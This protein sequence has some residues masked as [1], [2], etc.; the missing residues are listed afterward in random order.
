M[1]YFGD[2]LGNMSTYH[3]VNI[4]QQRAIIS[5]INLEVNFVYAKAISV[6]TDRPYFIN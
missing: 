4:A 5:E 3:L 6:G 1:R 2:V